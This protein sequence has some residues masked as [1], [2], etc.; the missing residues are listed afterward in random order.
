MRCVPYAM[1]LRRERVVLP[2]FFAEP[3][4]VANLPLSKLQHSPGVPSGRSPQ[5]LRCRCFQMSFL[6]KLRIG[7][8]LGIAAA[9][10]VLLVLFQAGNQIR[11]HWMTD[12]LDAE[13]KTA[14][15]VDR[16]LL[17]AEVALR[18][19][20]I[21]FR[22]IKGVSSAAELEGLVKRI[23]ELEGPST[24]PLDVAI[25]NTTDA[26]ERE[27]LA[28]TKELYKT[29]IAA[30]LEMA[31][32]HKV[33]L[34]DREQQSLA[35]RGWPAQLA[36]VSKLPAVASAPNRAELEK[37]FEKIDSE[38]KQGRLLSWVKIVRPEDQIVLKNSEVSFDT[39]KKL[40]D[41]TRAAAA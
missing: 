2:A 9:L 18:R 41:E 19:V 22:S 25:A 28:K 7:T 23:R 20:S 35:G 8:K 26:K 17:E 27:N 1:P 33:V 31:E 4:R 38:F 10:G 6:R 14:D 39:L 13:I 40:F 3:R 5:F 36:E 30:S 32:A 24:S 29:Y 16:A 12:K 34:T 21:Q 11:V 15:L 37:L